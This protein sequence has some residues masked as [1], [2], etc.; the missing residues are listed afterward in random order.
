MDEYEALRLFA[1]TLIENIGLWF[2]NLHPQS[3][4]NFE[5]Y[6][7]IFLNDFGI[8]NR[9]K[10][11]ELML[12]SNNLDHPYFFQLCKILYNPATCAITLASYSLEDLPNIISFDDHIKDET[13]DKH[14]MEESQS[15]EY[16]LIEAL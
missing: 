11:I 1:K 9:I 13:N 10:L 7:R 14:D 12:R 3:I 16:A 15:K 4:P 6:E 2:T 5:M 8:H